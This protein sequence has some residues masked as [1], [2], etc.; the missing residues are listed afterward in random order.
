MAALAVSDTLSN[1]PEQLESVAK[2]IGRS[3]NRRTVFEDIYH[4]KIRVKRVT[5]IAMRTGLSEKDVLGA[6]KYLVDHHVINQ[7]RVGG[8]VAYEKVGFFHK[9]KAKILG[10]VDH[11]ERLKKLATK[12]TPVVLNNVGLSF[13]KPGRARRPRTRLRRSAPRETQLRIAFL[14]SNPDDV[15][16]LRTDIELKAVNRAIQAAGNREKVS[17]RPYLAASFTDLLDALNEFRPKIL[18]F[19]GHGGMG[20]LY[21]DA[22]YDFDYEGAH[23]DFETINK[24]IAA[25][26]EAPTMLI[27]NAC[28]TEVGA[29]T[30]LGRVKAIVAMSDSIGDESA[31]LFAPRLYAALV[32][33]QSAAS[34]FAQAAATLDAAGVA[35]ADLPKLLLAHGVDGKTLKLV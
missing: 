27:F 26:D 5:D 31:L 10:Y 1:T 14:V 9:N 21:F 32:A 15:D 24:V 6:G 18:H 29:S 2:A 20:G 7:V 22:E 23:L 4:G 34:S 28:D 19:S 25:I 33:G 12:R 13:V 30:L 3:K 16:K 11:P 35:D 8:R 17:L